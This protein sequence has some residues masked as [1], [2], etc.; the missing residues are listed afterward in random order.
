MYTRQHKYKL[1]YET[2]IYSIIGKNVKNASY[3]GIYSCHSGF[4]S[5]SCYTFKCVKMC[6]IKFV[7]LRKKIKRVNMKNEQKH[8]LHYFKAL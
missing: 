6:T 1:V 2:Q 3:S 8:V 4:T 5:F 7:R